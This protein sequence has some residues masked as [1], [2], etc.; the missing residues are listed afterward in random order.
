MVR[1]SGQEYRLVDVLKT[2][3]Q[4]LIVPLS[5]PD[6]PTV[7]NPEAADNVSLGDL[8]HWYLAPTNPA[9]LAS[10]N[11][12]FAI[13]ADGLTS[14]NQFFPNLRVAVAA[15]SRPTRRS[16][17]SPRCRPAFSVSTRR[18]APSRWARWPTWW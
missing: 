18:M 6:A 4:P 2:R 11:I 9:Q 17:R 15:A 1:G 13:T 5:F 12:P 10:N 8:R 14:L 7:A 16:R 3:P